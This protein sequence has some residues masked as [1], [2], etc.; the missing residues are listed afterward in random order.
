MNLTK[1]II[2]APRTF[3]RKM[4]L[5]GVTPYYAYKDGRRTDV[6][7]GYRYSIVLPERAFDRIEVKIPG[8]QLVE[9]PEVRGYDEVSLAGME[10]HVYWSGSDYGVAIT[11]TGITL[12]ATATTKA[13]A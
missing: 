5:V 9:T 3:G 8:K 13:N 2:D 1:L 11:A 10:A 12:A 4:L 6:V 7:D